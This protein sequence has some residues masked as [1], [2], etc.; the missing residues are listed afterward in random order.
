M[1]GEPWRVSLHGGHSGEFCEHAT[2]TL[3]QVLESAVSCG[4]DVFG[5]SEHA[6]RSQTRFLYQTELDKGYDL[7][8]IHREFED[9][10]VAIGELAEEFSDRLT[11]LRGFEAEIVPEASFSEEMLAHRDRHDFEYMVGSVHYVNEISVDGPPEEFER[12]VESCGGLEEAAVRYYGN[13]VKLVEALK[14]EV[15]GHLDLIRRN[16]PPGAILD[17]PRIRRAADQALEAVRAADAILDL[18]T[19]GWRKGLGTPYPAPWL[20]Q[21]AHD[22]GIGFCFGDDSHGHDVGEGIDDARDYLLQHGVNRI[23]RLMRAGDEVVKEWVDL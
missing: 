3:R 2:G 21:R 6:P 12:M 17:T 20:V 7:A 13:I 5:V 15:I 9:Y 10:A 11:V 23:R 14:P 1:A 18:N 16:A 22:L 19:A 4:Y 8:R